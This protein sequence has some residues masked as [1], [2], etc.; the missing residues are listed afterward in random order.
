MHRVLLLCFILQYLEINLEW[1]SETFATTDDDKKIFLKLQSPA[2][3]HSHIFNRCLDML[4][5]RL[6]FSTLV[7]TPTGHLAEPFRRNVIPSKRLMLVIKA[8]NDEMHYVMYFVRAS[9]A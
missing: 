7:L 2:F 5:C 1:G 8:F 6:H 9:E 4:L 3:L